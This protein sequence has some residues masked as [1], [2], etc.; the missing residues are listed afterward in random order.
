MVCTP[1]CH[2]TGT[3]SSVSLGRSTLIVADHACMHAVSAWSTRV[4]L[5]GWV[6]VLVAQ[7][8]P[9]QCTA[10]RECRAAKKNI[11]QR[12]MTRAALLHTQLAS[13]NI[14]LSHIYGTRAN[15]DQR[16]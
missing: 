2:S 3:G 5:A 9:P 6:A 16:A 12:G 13:T 7:T 14:I 10:D 1:T 4:T 8:R 15:V 11:N